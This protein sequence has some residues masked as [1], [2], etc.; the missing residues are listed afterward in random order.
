[1]YVIGLKSNNNNRKDALHA[2][3]SSAREHLLI[4]IFGKSSK[5]DAHYNRCSHA[6]HAARENNL[7]KEAK[8]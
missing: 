1:M 7:M 8:K 5:K 2:L 6:H 4:C 3:A